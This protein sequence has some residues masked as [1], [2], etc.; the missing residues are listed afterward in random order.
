ML[1]IKINGQELEV[2]EGKTILEAAKKIGVEIPTL[3]YYPLLEPYAACR[4]CIVEVKRQDTSEI[5]TS[6]NTKVFEGMEVITN[7]EKVKKERG[8]IFELLLAQAPAA[9][10]LA[11]MAK[12]YGV[13][14]T[15]FEIKDAANKCILCGLC[16]RACQDVV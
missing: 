5:V 1:K 3:C 13:E 7:S 11:A 9:E 4:V 15:R 12:K 16:V 6:C 8:M 2:E 14:K 10:E